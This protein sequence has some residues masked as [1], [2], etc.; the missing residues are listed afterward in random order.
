MNYNFNLF[1]NFLN[2][3]FAILFLIDI[4]FRILV[5]EKLFIRTKANLTDMFAVFFAITRFFI[6]YYAFEGE[7]GSS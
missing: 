2:L 4:I 1:L 3:F 6:V 5:Q 7:K